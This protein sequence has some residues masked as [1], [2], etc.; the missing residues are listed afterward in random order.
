MEIK[1]A[2]LIL[3]AS[4]S[5]ASSI[6]AQKENIDKNMFM[7][8]K[9]NMTQEWDKVF[10]L[11]EKVN[12]SKITFHNRYGITLAADLYVPKNAEGKLA[13]IAVC[14]PFGAVKEQASGLYAQTLAER[15]FLTI[16]FDPSFTGESGGQPRYVASPDI[17]TEDFCAAVDY[18][19]TR[20]DV[21]KE[22]IGILGI[23][24]W[25]GLAIN[26]AAIDTRIKATV[27]STM[28]DMSRVT[29]NGYFDEADNAD[30][31]NA[32]REQLNAQRTEDYRNG[33]YALAGGVVDPL[34]EDAP[35][36]VKDYHAYYKTQ[37]GYHKRSLNSNGGWNKTSSLSFLNMPLLSFAGEI[38][39]AVLLIHGEKAHSR[40][41]SEDTF[42]KLKGDNKE[43]MIIPGASH[44]DLYDNLDKIPFDKIEQFYRE[45]L[46]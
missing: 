6:M 8:E 44:T 35:Q 29:E 2:C 14:G 11:S 43:L 26:A 34:P 16:A 46:K 21:D 7:E 32:M 28:Y 40:Y 13:A 4:F 5:L 17:N 41:F 37:R 3:I 45:N 19:S 20:N 38:R 25:G 24:G 10:P 42:K 23:C 18:L 30:A 1:K 39:N 22:R 12:H 15:G 31:R 27:S 9:L 36:F 33:T